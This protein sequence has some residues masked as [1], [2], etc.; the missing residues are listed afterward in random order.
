MTRYFQK[1]AL[2]LVLILCFQGLILNQLNISHYLLPMIYPLI[3]LYQIRNINTSLL[4]LIGF[5]L[6]LIMDLFT[7]TGGAHAVACTVIAYLR[8]FFLSSLGH[9]DM[10][11]EQIKPSITNLGLKNYAVFL[12]LM[13]AIHHILFFTLEAFSITILW[14]TL[15]RTIMSLIFSWTLIMG[16]QYL[17]ISKEK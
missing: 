16:I 10:G 13:L 5:F 11:S 3:I 4:L 17:L 14:S 15:L 7:N 1:Y 9:A 2:F 12:F 6:G 8:P